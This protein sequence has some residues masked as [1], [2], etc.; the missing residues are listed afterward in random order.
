MSSVFL[1]DSEMNE[2]KSIQNDYDESD[3]SSSE[4]EEEVE[5]DPAELAAEKVHDLIEMERWKIFSIILDFGEKD[6]PGE[7]IQT[8]YAVMKRSSV[9]QNI[10]PDESL[11]ERTL[12][13]G[14]NPNLT[15][16]YVEI[17]IQYL[18]ICHEDGFYRDAPKRYC[19]SYTYTGN[20]HNCPERGIQYLFE[21]GQII[22]PF[23]KSHML[24]PEFVC[25]I[26][27]TANIMGWNACLDG[28]FA[29]VVN[30]CEMKTVVDMLADRGL[31]KFTNEQMA[32]VIS[33]FPFFQK[34][35]R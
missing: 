29:T 15:R 28:I 13:L 33:K 27:E 31:K 30:E 16:E 34:K 18:E 2:K 4:S 21:K 25:S 11:V 26:M 19:D 32:R 9:F 20:N 10:L 8:N 35:K 3:D 12:Y 6:D 5:R 7:K 23:S 22:S 24:D 1:M 17:L 14:N